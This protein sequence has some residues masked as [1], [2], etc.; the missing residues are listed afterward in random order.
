MKKLLGIIVLGLLLSGNAYSNEVQDQKVLETISMKCKYFSYKIDREKDY[1][2]VYK[3]FYYKKVGYW[4]IYA[5]RSKI[6]EKTIL[7]E[8]ILRSEKSIEIGKGGYRLE[9]Y[10]KH[11]ELTNGICKQCQIIL[12][13][14]KLRRKGKGNWKGKPYNLNEKCK[15]IKS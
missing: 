5:K 4:N 3:K 6:D 12:D 8:T 11:S 2:T 14:K 1:A 15:L 9:T 13:F 7:P 10:V